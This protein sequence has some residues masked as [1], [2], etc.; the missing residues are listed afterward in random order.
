ML[1]QFKEGMLLT[2]RG[3]ELVQAR[4]PSGERR[5]ER[6]FEKRRA[7]FFDAYWKRAAAA[8]GAEIE[9]VG[10]EFYRLRK[11]GRLTY[12]RRGEVML[13]D[14]LTLD[15]AGNKPLAHK[16]LKEQGYP[17]PEFLE[18]GLRDIEAARAFM[19]AQQ[20]PCV[21]KPASGGAAGRGITTGINCLDRLRKASFRAAVYSSNARLIIEK[22]YQGGNYRLLYLGGEFIDAIRRDAP[23]VT[24]DGAGSLEALVQ[25]E[26]QARLDSDEVTALSPLILDLDAR[27]ALADRGLSLGHVPPEGERVA[28]K[29]AS[30]QNSRFENRSVKDEIH[31]SIIEYGREI[32]RVLNVA[33]SGVD[34]MIVDHSAALS[35]SGCVVNEINTTP[36]LHHHA[37]IANREREVD[38]GRLVVDYIFESMKR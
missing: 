37:L 28:V 8:A 36:G 24:G 15:I 9:A 13:D 16:L 27:Y 23:A 11:N 38:V 26:N 10:Y 4:I 2:R 14:H 32:S 20:G 6:L 17:V 1:E 34:M 19:E 29:N 25:S 18:Y 35:G 12:V 22:Q 3:L 33:L 30:N 7:A 31:P 21:V 5:L